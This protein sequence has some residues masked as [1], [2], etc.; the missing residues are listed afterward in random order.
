MFSKGYLLWVIKSWDCVKKSKILYLDLKY[1]Y[2]SGL[3]PAENSLYFY[4]AF[5]IISISIPQNSNKHLKTLWEKEKI[6]VSNII[7]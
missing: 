7:V 3:L 6:D 4:L 5:K 2:F 1:Q